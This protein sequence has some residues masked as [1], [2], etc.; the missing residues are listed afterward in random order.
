VKEV[1]IQPNEKKESPNTSTAEAEKATQHGATDKG[2]I[3]GAKN[4]E[5]CFP[6]SHMT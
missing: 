3:A 4:G 2:G 6:T 1:R 5:I